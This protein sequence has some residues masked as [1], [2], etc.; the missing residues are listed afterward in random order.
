MPV[1]ARRIPP[2]F[3]GFAFGLA[4][5]AEVWLL[6]AHQHRAPAVI[7]AVLAG[8]AA[9]VWLAVTV[10]YFRYLTADRLALWKDLRDPIVAPFLSLAVIAPMILAVVG[11]YPHAAS[12]GRVLFN[13]FLVLTVLLA[14]WFTG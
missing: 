2:N 3:F 10:A 6:A 5:L 11:V 9:L 12:A 8:I 1:P 13:I 7:S 4:G 14:G